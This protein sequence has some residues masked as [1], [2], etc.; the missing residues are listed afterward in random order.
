[1][2]G[3]RSR[4]GADRDD[5]PGGAELGAF[6]PGS[7]GGTRKELLSGMDAVG[8]AAD[9]RD[10]GN[11]EP[12]AQSRAPIPAAGD[13]CLG[14]AVLGNGVRIAE[15]GIERSKNLRKFPA[16][17]RGS[18]IKTP[19]ETTGLMDW[20]LTADRARGGR[21]LRSLSRYLTGNFRVNR[22]RL[23]PTYR[24]GGRSN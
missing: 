19:Q 17:P 8:A 10:R 5:V 3:Q 1:M 22:F 12:L 15:E 23:M 13:D 16:H 2:A 14:N 24:L 21:E 7:P 20:V 9:E 18:P 6:V 4:L 11:G